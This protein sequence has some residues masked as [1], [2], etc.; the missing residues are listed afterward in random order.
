MALGIGSLFTA[1]AR[2]TAD[3]MLMIDT[4]KVRALQSQQVPLADIPIDTAQVETQVEVLKSETIGLSVIKDQR[5][6]EDPEFVAPGG[7]LL[8]TVFGL[9]AG[10]IDPGSVGSS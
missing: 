5:L 4:S 10:L 3:T 2:Y 8:G 1:S 7:G 9:L 6:T